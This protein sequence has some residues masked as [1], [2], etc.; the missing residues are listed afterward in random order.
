[1]WIVYGRPRKET[2]R[3]TLKLEKFEEPAYH[4]TRLF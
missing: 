3:I 4:D 1:M 2:K